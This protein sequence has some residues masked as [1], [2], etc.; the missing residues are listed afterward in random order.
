MCINAILARLPT[1]NVE[2][3]IDID[4]IILKLERTFST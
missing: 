2:K 3:L 4:E 1:T